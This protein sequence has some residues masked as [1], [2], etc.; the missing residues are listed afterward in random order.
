MGR[1][2]G[3]CVVH[4]TRHTRSRAAEAGKSRRARTSRRAAEV[5]QYQLAAER[6]GLRR[7]SEPGLSFTLLLLHRTR[8]AVCEGLFHNRAWLQKAL[9]RGLARHWEERGP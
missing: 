8:L 6:L 9:D 1:P 5:C 3:P 7:P 4:G 2:A